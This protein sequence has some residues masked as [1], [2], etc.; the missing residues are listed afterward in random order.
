ME[1]PSADLTKE[2][3][4]ILA[5]KWVDATK[6]DI[7]N[8]AKRPYV[9]RVTTVVLLFNYFRSHKRRSAAKYFKFLVLSNTNTKAK[10]NKLDMISIINDNIFKFQ[11]SMN[12]VLSM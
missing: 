4:F 1:K 6:D 2:I 5:L 3:L 10:V 7:Q 9:S 12:N 11:I 8:N